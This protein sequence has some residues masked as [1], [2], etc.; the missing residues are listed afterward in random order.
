MK[1]AAAVCAGIAVLFLV[2]ALVV[3]FAP[4]DPEV[5]R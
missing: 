5:L 1:I 2:A 3:S 4:G